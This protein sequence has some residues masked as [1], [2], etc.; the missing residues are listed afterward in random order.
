M[1]HARII[2]LITAA[3][4]LTIGAA[5]AIS[6][7]PPPVPQTLGIWDTK[8]TQF[9]VTDCHKCHGDDPTIVTLH[10]N[11]I[12]TTTP[13]VSCY[14]A[15]G[16]LPTT[17]VTGCHV[18]VASPSGGYTFQDFRNCFNCHTGN[19]PHHGPNSQYAVAQDCQHCHGKI[20]IDNPNDGH[21]IPT[22]TI[23]GDSTKGGVTPN[24]VG[25]QVVD[26]ANPLN[27][28]TVQGCAACHQASSAVTP[29]IYSNQDTHHGTNIGN[30]DGIGSCTWCHGTGSNAFTIRACEACHGVKSLH[31]IQA[32]SPNAN[33]LGTIVPGNEDAG[34][35]H[36]GNNWDCVGCHGSWTGSAT[37]DTTA[38][39]PSI[40]TLNVSVIRAGVA[41]TTLIITGESFVNLDT[42]GNEYKPTVTLTKGTSTITLTP[43]SVTT[44][45]VKVVLPALE[46]GIYEVRVEKNGGGSNLKK[47][48]VAPQQAIKN[49]TL[50]GSTLTISGVGFGSAPSGAEQQILGVF[51]GGTQAKIVS[52]SDSKVVA[53][54]NAFGGGKT[55]TVQTLFGPVDGNIFAASKK[56]K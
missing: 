45:E 34:Y 53:S 16:T 38:T 54:S 36:I 47:L 13:A 8:F 33:N 10:H 18:L 43:F 46:Q 30:P 15:T 11:L 2:S 9:T 1:K 42:L 37:Q 4:A 14:N 23:N 6:A 28:I 31:N 35:G 20:L 5:A 50:S 3:A 44:S 55:V 41:S 27:T 52:W 29:P 25:R 7:T 26:P 39:A 22:Y 12:Y 17:L 32:N 56:A 40:S 51:V 48:I 49:A 21:Y 19:S 24:P